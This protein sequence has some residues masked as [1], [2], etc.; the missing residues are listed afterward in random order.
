M[1]YVAQLLL[2]GQP[3]ATVGDDAAGNGLDLVC[4]NPAAI[5]ALE[6]FLAGCRYEGEPVGW[7]RLLE[8]LADEVYL[9]VAV[10]QTTADGEALV[11]TV[12]DSGH[13]RALRPIHPKPSGWAALTRLGTDLARESTSRWEIWTGGSWQPLPTYAHHVA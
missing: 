10:K 7:A 9:A 4:T 1:A 8:A 2:D 6:Q 5:E 12:D 11:R 13:T 3:V